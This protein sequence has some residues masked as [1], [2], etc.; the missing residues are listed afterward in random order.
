MAISY[1]KLV[2]PLGVCRCQVHR[3][4]GGRKRVHTEGIKTRHIATERYRAAD[5][6][7]NGVHGRGGR[8]DKCRAGIDGGRI[9]TAGIDGFAIHS[10]A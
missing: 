10:D 3:Q 1:L 5:G 8:A 2:H 6:A 7:P 9:P 4:G